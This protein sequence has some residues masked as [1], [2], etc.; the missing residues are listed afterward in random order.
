M[1]QN[2]CFARFGDGSSIVAGG[3]TWP[4]PLAEFADR[5]DD[6]AGDGMAANDEPL[7]L[8]GEAGSYQKADF[9]VHGIE[10]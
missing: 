3:W 6:I 9:P 5:R 1:F 8:G 4:F 7:E 2:F 10:G